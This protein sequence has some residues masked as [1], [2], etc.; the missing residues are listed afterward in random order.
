MHHNTDQVPAWV[1]NTYGTL[2]NIIAFI[3]ARTSDQGADIAAR[4]LPIL[5]PMPNAISLYHVSQ[6][7]YGFT[8]GQAFAFAM[9]IECAMFAVIEVA[10]HLFDG[11]QKRKT[12]YRIP[13]AISIAVVIIVMLLV[14]VF[15]Y[16]TEVATENGHAILALLPALSGASAIALA[17]KRW[18]ARNEDHAE[19]YTVMQGNSQGNPAIILQLQSTIAS[20]EMDVLELRNMQGREGISPLQGNTI[21]QPAPLQA[22]AQEQTIMQAIGAS[23]NERIAQLRNSGIT[24]NKQLAI[25]LKKEN[26]SGNKIAT[27]L[28]VNASSV[29]RWLKD[30]QPMPVAGD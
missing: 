8:D 27:A 9:A 29:S 21:A 20:L 2:I 16:A 6:T 18:H 1:R 26:F 14:I 15:V 3:V 5:A 30:L 10:L 24:D 13:F 4:A 25:E 19:T 23:I 12:L 22:I 17:L 7:A 28:E 11:L